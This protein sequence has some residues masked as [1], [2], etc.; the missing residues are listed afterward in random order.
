VVVPPVDHDCSL[1]GV[2]AELS[3][4]VAKLQ[5][6][7]SDPRLVVVTASWRLPRRMTH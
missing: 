2:V 7:R 3:N 4:Q 1:L 6:R 5:R